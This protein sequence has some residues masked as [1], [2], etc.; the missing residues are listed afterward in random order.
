MNK[1][2]NQ[3]K[4]GQAHKSSTVHNSKNNNNNSQTHSGTSH[5]STAA[6]GKGN[7][8]GKK[9]SKKKKR[10]IV[11]AEVVVVLILLIVLYFWMKLSRIDHTGE[12]AEEDLSINEIDEEAQEVM[13]G[14]TNIALFGLDNRSNGSYSSGNSDV[15]MIASINDETKDVKLVSVYR[16]S[17]LNVYDDSFKK[18]NAAYAKGGA[19]GAVA[20]LNQ[21]LDLE[22]KDYVAVDFNAMIEVVDKLGG[23]ELEITNQEAD[24]INMYMD[25]MNETIGTKVSYVK[26]GGTYLLNGVQTTAYCRIRGTTGDDFKRAERQRTVLQL[27]FDKAKKADI[28]TLNGIVDAVMDDISTS[29]KT[30]DIL[31]LATSI[32]QYKL[33]ENTGFPFTHSPVTVGKK[34]EVVVPATL[35]TNVVQL[36]QYLYADNEYQPSDTILELSEK[37]SKETGIKEGDGITYGDDYV[38]GETETD[39]S[40]TETDTTKSKE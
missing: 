34:G 9:L 1:E 6:N 30:T 31:G 10:I 26:G 25:E 24:F 20:M 16:D 28:L 3:S 23:L 36:H 32:T 33:T 15:I 11:I 17:Y 40:D 39:T 2:Q 7:G 13:D 8:H 37:I 12:I 5:S 22:I 4:K 14:Y 21:N 29:M 38:P 18:C 27:M 19:E 35:E